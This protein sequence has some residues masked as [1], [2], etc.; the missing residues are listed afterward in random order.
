M[1]VD[2]KIRIKYLRDKKRNPY[3]VV[4]MDEQGNIG[5]SMRWKWDARPFTKSFG[6]HIAIER[7]YKGSNEPLPH[8]VEKMVIYMNEYVKKEE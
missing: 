4:V 6:K 7:L 3:G 1:S 8:A 5:W 2:K